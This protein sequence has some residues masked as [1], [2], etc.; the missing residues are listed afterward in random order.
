MWRRAAAISGGPSNMGATPTSLEQS[1]DIESTAEVEPRA[2]LL[3]SL[4][5]RIV[6]LIAAGYE[7]YLPALDLAEN[8]ATLET[9]D[10]PVLETI[11]MAI[12]KLLRAQTDSDGQCRDTA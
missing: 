9:L 6:E 1:S 8:N 10:E 12:N 5:M 2:F 7:E 3:D 4:R 11:I